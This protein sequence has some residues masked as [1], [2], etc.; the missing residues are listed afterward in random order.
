MSAA[1]YKVS[2]PIQ[3]VPYA[4]QVSGIPIRGNA[5]TW[6]YQ[7]AGRYHRSNM[8]IVG[9]VMVLSKTQRLRYGHIAV[10]KRVIDSRNIEVE[11]SNWGGD[12][13][14]RSFVYK[15]MPVK[16]VSA[17]NDWS[18][19]RFWNYPSSSYGSVYPVSGFI[20]P[21]PPT[22]SETISKPTPKPLIK[23]ISQSTIKPPVKPAKKLGPIY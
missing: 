18:R 1:Y 2:E 7:A 9:S 14:T 19:A 20:Y 23:P 11:H 15:R 12:R 8:P 4:R 22:G 13:A 17:G 6:W 21:H 16:D 5:H 3:C 10:V